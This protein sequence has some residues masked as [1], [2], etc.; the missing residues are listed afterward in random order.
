MFNPDDFKLSFSSW[1]APAQTVEE[2]V[3]TAKASGYSGLELRTAIPGTEPH[4]HGVE[5]DM[6]APSL[7]DVRHKLADGGIELV[8]IAT[9]VSLDA[10]DTEKLID[11]LKRYVTLAETLGAPWVR[12]LGGSLST[13]RGEIAGAV[14]AA[15][16][17]LAEAVAFAEQ[18]KVSLLLETHGD[19]ATTK[20]VREVVK[21]VYSD[22]FGVLW[23]VVEPFRALET[24]EEAYD[25]IGGQVKHVHI[26]DVRYVEGRLKLEPAIIGEGAVPIGTAIK[27]L[28]HDGYEGFLSVETR[29]GPPEDVL[30]QCAKI[31]HDFISDAFPEQE[32]DAQEAAVEAGEAAE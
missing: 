27:Y 18:T 15:S 29:I 4:A 16:D 8:C 25:N 10:P 13:E 2:L 6:A 19:Y 24:M 11:D 22:H 31:L 14:D 21:Q 9:G 30:P 23:D 32:E 5:H 12:V 28:A 17:A 1:T 3:E 7:A 20:Y 26:H